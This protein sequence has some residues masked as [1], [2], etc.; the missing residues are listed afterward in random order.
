MKIQTTI[1][2]VIA[3]TAFVVTGCNKQSGSTPGAGSDTTA[4][5]AA[6]SVDT[7]KLTAAFAS[8]D[9]ATKSAVGTAVTAIKGADY[10]GAVTQ[11]QA[12]AGKF[13]LTDDQTAAVKEVVASVQKAISDMAAKA[14]D[15]AGKAA[16]SAGQAASDAT[17]S[18]T[19]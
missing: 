17:K 12:L 18:L 1:L 2:T 4:P 6:A 13:K 10:S 14:A 7:S 5:A 19:K 9:D 11:L 3:A 15:A 16:T 8:A